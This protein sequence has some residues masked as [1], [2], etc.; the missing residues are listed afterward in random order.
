M[1]RGFLLIAFRSLLISVPS[2]NSVPT[3]VNSVVNEPLR[4]GLLNHGV[5]RGFTEFT[6]AIRTKL[7]FSKK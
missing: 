3:S 6:E 4:L 7:P 2:V 5:H 1:Q